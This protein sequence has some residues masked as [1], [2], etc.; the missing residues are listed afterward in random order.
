MEDKLEEM[1]DAIQEIEDAANQKATDVFMKF[2]EEKLNEWHF[3]NPKREVSISCGM[4]CLC[5]HIDETL[6]DDV[7]HK[8][9]AFK[10]LREIMEM[11]EELTDRHLDE[12]A[13]DFKLEPA[14]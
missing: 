12:Y 3:R 4:G 8:K 7:Q 2:A 1:R 10:E 6:L 13:R 5:I 14:I 11:A 9:F